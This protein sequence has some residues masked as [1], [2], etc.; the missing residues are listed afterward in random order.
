MKVMLDLDELVRQGKLNASEAERLKA[1]A[2][3]ETNTLGSNIFLAFGIVAVVAGAGVLLPTL[4]TALIL[5]GMLFALGL[6]LTIA[7]VDR[8]AVFA[9]IV[10]VIGALVLGAAIIALAGESLLVK[11]A[12]AA[13]LAVTAVIA[14]SGLLAGLA[15][16]MLGAAI[17][18]GADMWEP[19]SYLAVTIAIFSALV[20]ALYIVSLR[21]EPVYER[22]AIIAM[23]TGILVINLAFLC[24]SL[25]GDSMLGLDSLVFTVGW[26]VA[27]I[28]LG[29]WAVFANRR[30]V[31]NSAAVF[32]S[33]HFFTQWFIALGAQPFSILVGGLL[34]IG[35]G[36]GLAR[37]NQIQH[38]RRQLS[39]APSQ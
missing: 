8:W 6:G 33:I 31:V 7:K 34:L 30:W 23:R 25:F 17:M 3:Q 20:L 2:L 5:G 16:L 28:L 32:G 21:L 4:E 35:F 10:M 14:T 39:K 26:A 1:F 22:L 36:L 9:Q 18:T 19:T 27:L 37:F 11:L 38:A 29:V 24:G 13:G 15:M 12:L